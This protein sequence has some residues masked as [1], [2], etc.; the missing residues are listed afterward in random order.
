MDV[1]RDQGH[2][3]TYDWTVQVRQTGP[4]HERNADPGYLLKCAQDDI[5]GV[6]VAQR[7][8]ALGH[9]NLCGTLIEI[10]V[11][12]GAATPVL[13]VG[14]FP[15]SIFWLLPR[16]DRVST[17]TEAAEFMERYRVEA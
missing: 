16:F 1:L 11:A 3:I 13:L 7:V 6:R 8:I 12:V 2:L 9:P 5:Y 15:H 4:D 17:D 10:G 14:E